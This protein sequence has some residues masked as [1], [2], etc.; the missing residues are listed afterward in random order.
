WLAFRGGETLT[1]KLGQSAI[2]VVTR[3]MGL[4][5]AVVGV[6]MLIEGIHQ[7]AAGPPAG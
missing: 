4:I 7:A 1:Q 5:L 3:L 2:A 6:Q